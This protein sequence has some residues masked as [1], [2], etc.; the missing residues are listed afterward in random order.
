MKKSLF[1]CVLAIALVFAFAAIAGATYQGFEPYAPTTG[2]GAGAFVS[3]GGMANWGGGAAVTAIPG[4][5]PYE[6]VRGYNANTANAPT[7]KIHGGYVSTS[8]KCQVCHS[9]HRA[10]I[11]PTTGVIN[12][13][14]ALTMGGTCEGCHTT[15]G[16]TPSNLLIEWNSAAQTAHNGNGGTGQTSGCSTCHTEGI[17]GSGG[18]AYFGMNAYMLGRSQDSWIATRIMQQRADMNTLLAW[19]VDGTAGIPTGGAT[20]SGMNANVFA[21]QKTALTGATCSAT[22]CHTQG[23]FPVIAKGASSA[24]GLATARNA[25]L[26]GH[27]VPGVNS[28]HVTNTSC[29]PCHPGNVSGPFRN[30]MLGTGALATNLNVDT[31]YA[32]NGF[33]SAT[34]TAASIANSRAYG[35]DQCHDA[36]GVATG[37]TAFPHGTQGINVFVRNNATST[38]VATT[39]LNGKNVWMYRMNIAATPAWST[40]TGNSAAPAGASLTA[41]VDPTVAVIANAVNDGVNYGVIRDGACL[42]CHVAVDMDSYANVPSIT[43]PPATT[44][45]AGQVRVGS[46]THTNAT[47]NTSTVYA[48]IGATTAPFAV[49]NLFK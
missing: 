48:P 46:S 26:T 17:H 8:A 37:S 30:T 43:A 6:V 10:P 35:C 27:S 39:A 7:S 49:I 5:M 19:F 11:S 18:S 2:T 20:P 28:Q 21:R 3:Q 9:V 25:G 23:M 45:V 36:V 16:A 24:G 4:F 33:G 29:G 38:G 22:G 14:I 41:L 32:P 13:Q 12:G 42:K 47:G 44:A 31:A 1:V 34:V 40:G 15:D